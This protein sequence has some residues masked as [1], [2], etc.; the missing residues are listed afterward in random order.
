M[1]RIKHPALMSALL[2][3]ASL[4]SLLIPAV[5]VV[6]TTPM[7]VLHLVTVSQTSL[8]IIR[9]TTGVTNVSL[10]RFGDMYIMH[11]IST[12]TVIS[13]TSSYVIP[14]I[15]TLTRTSTSTTHKLV[16]LSA[17]IGNLAT[18][19]V[20]TTVCIAAAGVF[21]IGRRSRRTVAL[22]GPQRPRPSQISDARYVVFLKRLE[23]M[24]T[25]GEIAEEIYLKLKDE[26]R[27]RLERSVS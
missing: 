11:V 19:L 12:T 26:Y 21:V 24:K 9:L 1:T 3:A 2:I 8:A 6:V 22:A 16:A 23:Q 15:A 14:Y 10:S 7:T 25:R 4:A 20:L 13:M 5:T 18:T 27:K 17:L